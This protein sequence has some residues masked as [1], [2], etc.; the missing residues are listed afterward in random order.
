VKPGEDR[1]HVAFLSTNFAR[2]FAS[3]F[4]EWDVSGHTPFLRTPEAVSTGGGARARQPLLL[5]P[6]DGSAHVPIGWVDVHK[7]ECR[8][9][10]YACLLAIHRKRFQNVAFGVDPDAYGRFVNEARTFFAQ[11][12][13]KVE[14]EEQP[15]EEGPQAIRRPEHRGFVAEL[16]H[17]QRTLVIVWGVCGLLLAGLAVYTLVR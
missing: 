14:L 12:Q 6:I 10:T 9:R 7:K 13:M 17:A 2:A 11:R 3:H 5:R 15:A 8:L 1:T 16:W 4:Y